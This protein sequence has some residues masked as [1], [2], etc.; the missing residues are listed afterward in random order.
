[1]S[2]SLQRRLVINTIP[3]FNNHTNWLIED[4]FQSNPNLADRLK[5]A[6]ITHIVTCGIQSECCVESTSKGAL[7]AGFQVSLLQG[8]HSTYDTKEA[9]ALEI[10]SAVEERIAALGGKVVAYRS[11]LSSWKTTGVVC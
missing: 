9:T 4:T 8:A 5:A 7:A 10:E 2:G 1:M 3:N 6:G 11:A